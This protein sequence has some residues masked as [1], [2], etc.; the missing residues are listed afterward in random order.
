MQTNQEG[1]VSLKRHFILLVF[2]FESK[3]KEGKIYEKH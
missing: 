3:K 1:V 2:Y